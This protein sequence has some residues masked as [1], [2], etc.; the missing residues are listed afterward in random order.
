MAI[1]TIKKGK[2]VEQKA[3]A[4]AKVQETVRGILSDIQT[5]GDDAVRELSQK[6]D[7]LESPKLQV[8][9]RPDPGNCRRPAGSGSI[10]HQICAGTDTKLR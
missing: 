8:V 3:D 5:R 9:R 6:F 1:R 7:R 10:R 2:T 4:D